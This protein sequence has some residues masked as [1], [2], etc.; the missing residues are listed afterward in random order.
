VLQSL[1]KGGNDQQLAVV[2]SIADLNADVLLLTGID[3][4]A[5]GQTLA[6]LAGVLA[7]LIPTVCRCGPIRVWPRGLI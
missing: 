6:A 1:Q 3:Y 4:D 5:R 7:R 2:E